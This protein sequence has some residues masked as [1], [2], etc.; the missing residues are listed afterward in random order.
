MIR[1][2]QD[3][4]RP[5]QP[6]VGDTLTVVHRVS[7]PIG[8]LVQP[9]G[10]TDSTLASLIGAPLVSREG[11]SVRIAYTMAVWATGR[12]NL[13][14]PGA[15]TVAGDGTVDTLPDATVTY[16]VASLLPPDVAAE[17]V[18]PRAAQPWVERTEPS[19]WPFLV[20]LIPV[21]LLLAAVALWWR[22]RGK[23]PVAPASPP[24]DAAAVRARLERWQASGE[25]ALVI[26]HLLGAL[27]D[28]EATANWRAQV[29]AIRFDPA[30]RGQLDLL[31]Q[32][33]MQLFDAQRGRP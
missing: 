12:H 1:Q 9:R 33:G 6:T 5:A 7:V 24:A 27:P 19:G 32:H 16:N 10:P 20:L 8:T 15:I 28:D 14:I 25:S 30:A 22:R 31:V 23:A 21:L 11:D 17:S 2:Q 3:P 26:D 13:V 18:A 29:D 4:Q